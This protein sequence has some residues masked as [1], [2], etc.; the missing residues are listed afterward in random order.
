MG[1]IG[2]LLSGATLFLN[3]LVLLKKANAKS[4]A[5]LNL[6]VG[7]LQIVIPFYLLMHIGAGKWELFNT[8][9]IFFFGVTYLLVG[10]TNLKG[11]NGTGLGWFSLWV[12][13][14]SVLYTFVNLVM[15]HDVVNG[16]LWAMW[17]YLWYL[18]FA[19]IVLGKKIDRY[20]GIVAMIQSW[21]TV[22][23]PAF[24]M[25]LGIWQDP[26]I[27]KVWIVVLGVAILYFIVHEVK[28][29][30]KNKR[31]QLFNQTGLKNQ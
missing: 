16:L 30:V 27:L 12:S 15:I 10:F 23:L 6:V 1:S 5:Y 26:I 24:L 25:I 13:I 20:T 17:A 18:F 8:A 19:G 2:L 9:G 4:A 29:F 3:S 21:T 22:T 28:S 11:L 7:T 14:M 31:F